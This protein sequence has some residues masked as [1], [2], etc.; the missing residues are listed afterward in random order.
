MIQCLESRG[1]GNTIFDL[2]PLAVRV[3]VGLGLIV[4]SNPVIVLFVGWRALPVCPSVLT[5]PVLTP[6]FFTS[7]F[8]FLL[9]RIVLPCHTWL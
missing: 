5:L 4:I 3:V 1:L 2:L 6:M 8:G 7:K 9:S